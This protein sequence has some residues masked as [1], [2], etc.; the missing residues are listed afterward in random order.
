MIYGYVR[1]CSES[2]FNGKESKVQ[3]FEGRRQRDEMMWEDYS[4]SFDALKEND[5]I[6][7]T[8]YNNNPKKTK[9]EFMKELLE[10]KDADHDVFGLIQADDFHIQF[11]PFTKTF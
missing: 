9:E 5:V 3:L 6:G 1:V 11:E 7:E 10:S 4:D 2:D 8:D